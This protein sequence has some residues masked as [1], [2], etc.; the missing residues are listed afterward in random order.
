MIDKKIARRLMEQFRGMNAAPKNREELDIRIE[1][2]AAAARSE[3]HARE[4]CTALLDRL[5][6]FPNIADLR[7]A[8]ANTADPAST[9][10]RS[11]ARGCPWCQGTGWRS[12]QSPFC[13]SAAY[14][15]DHRPE[16]D[17]R[18]GISFTP[19]TISRYM[20][21]ARESA[22]RQE[23]WLRSRVDKPSAGFRRITQEDVDAVIAERGI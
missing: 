8:C 6:F 13:L 19:A 22:R 14:P 11:A 1:A 4:V 20:Q 3:S 2:L 9:E 10:A 18:M 12:A 21:E 23:E 17:K 16:S 15:C 5:A 7:Q